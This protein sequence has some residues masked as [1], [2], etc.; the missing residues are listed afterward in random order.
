MS[1]WQCILLLNFCL[2]FHCELIKR[3]TLCVISRKWLKIWLM[4][5]KKQMTVAAIIYLFLLRITEQNRK[6][7]WRKATFLLITFTLS[8]TN[9][10]IQSQLNWTEAKSLDTLLTQSKRV[11][12]VGHFYS[13]L[14]W[15]PSIRTPHRFSMKL[16][17][18]LLQ[19]KAI[20]KM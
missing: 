12:K 13:I 10:V 5:K 20:L 7:F 19:A 3:L 2:V 14:R 4:A 6:V 15:F 18:L 16:G 8:S 9:V 11:T 17:M 1:L